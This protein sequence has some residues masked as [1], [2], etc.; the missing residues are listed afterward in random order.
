MSNVPPSS[1]PMPCLA[2]IRV[3]PI[4]TSLRGGSNTPT[5]KERM[6]RHKIVDMC[7]KRIRHIGEGVLKDK[8]RSSSPISGGGKERS[9]RRTWLR[10]LAGV[11]MTWLLLCDSRYPGVVQH[12]RVL[13]TVTILIPF[14]LLLPPMVSPFRSLGTYTRFPLHSPGVHALYV[15]GLVSPSTA[16]I[17]KTVASGTREGTRKNATTTSSGECHIPESSHNRYVKINVEYSTWE[18]KKADNEDERSMSEILFPLGKESC[19]PLGV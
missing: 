19:L 11:V 12:G 6:V 17:Q 15:C 18:K 7:L 5:V 10:T 2:L 14:H 9:K 8:D 3:K 4:S 16:R 1:L 13:S